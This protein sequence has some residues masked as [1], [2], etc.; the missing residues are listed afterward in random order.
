MK[1]FALLAALATVFTPSTAI[2][3]S[4]QATIQNFGY[5]MKNWNIGMA[6]A[7]MANLDS[8]SY[9]TSCVTAA[10]ATSDEVF[11]LLDFASYLSGGFNLGIF[12]NSINVVLIKLM[13]QYEYC[14]VNELYIKWDQIMSN[15]SDISG[16]TVNLILMIALG[17]TN[18]DTAPYK[19]YDLWK[20]GWAIRNWTQIGQGFQLLFAQLAKYDAPEFSIEVNI[21]GSI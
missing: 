13:Q 17:W 21:M 9:Y 3:S 10:S 2:S 7:L 14:G 1:K 20:A 4:A 8:T 15:I 12:M 5:H 11:L 6:T 16:T 19:V 18:K